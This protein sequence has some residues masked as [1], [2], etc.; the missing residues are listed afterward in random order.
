LIINNKSLTGFSINKV[1]QK[2]T[3]LDWIILEKTHTPT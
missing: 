3:F 1:I 2:E